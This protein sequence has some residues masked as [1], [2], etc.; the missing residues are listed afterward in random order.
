[1]KFSDDIMKVNMANQNLEE[2][3]KEQ[4]L[5]EP[6]NPKKPAA[7]DLTFENVT[8]AYPGTTHKAV[9]DLSF[10]LPQGGTLAI[11]GA[12]GSGKS[13]AASLA[14]RFFD[15]DSGNI[16]IGGINIKEIT[17]ED[18][19][20]NVSFVFQSTKLLKGTL[21]YNISMGCGDVPRDK[22]IEAAQKA[23]CQDILDKLPEGIDTV[24]GS[25][26]IYLSGGECQRIALARAILKDAPIVILDEATAFSDPENERL[27]QKSFEELTK[28]KTLIMIAHRLTTVQNASCILVMDHGHLVEQGTHSELL[29]KNGVYA[30]MWKDY[31]SSIEWNIKKTEVIA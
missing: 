4:P 27:I 7:Y 16:K 17:K 23:Q 10:Y 13:T 5:E 9:E 25:D 21:A 20:N 28:D 30:S 3:M 1:M 15:M 6:S 29:A 12:S 19:T 18:L 8:F 24:Y 31:Q 2:L 14:A 26:G 22:I 11:V